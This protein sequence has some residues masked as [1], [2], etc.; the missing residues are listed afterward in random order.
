MTNDESSPNNEARKYAV[1]CQ[2]A[3]RHLSFVIP[4][5]F[6]LRHL[7]EIPRLTLGMTNKEYRGRIAPSPTG[8][9][10][11]G[12]AMTFWRAQ[13]RARQVGGKLVLRIED[14]DR[15]RCRREFADAIIEDLHWFGLDW[16]EGPDIG[17]PFAPYFQSQRRSRYLEAWEKLRVG[18]FVYPCKC[19]RKDVMEA[20]LAPHDESEEPIYPGT[21]RPRSSGIESAARR[22]E[23]LRR[24][25]PA[26]GWK[27]LQATRLPLQGRG[28]TVAAA[29]SA[30]GQGDLPPATAAAT[31]AAQTHWRFRVPDGPRIEFVDERVGKQSAVAGR[32]FGDFIVWRRDDVPAYQLAVVVD[33]AAMRI[34]EVVRGEDLLRSTFRQL[35][36]YRALDLTPPQFFHTQ[37]VV[38]ESGKRLAKRHGA[39]NLRALRERGAVPEEL[40]AMYIPE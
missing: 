31:S 22:A 27:N 19:S 25:V 16:D 15:D 33:D 8:L 11:L 37:L 13:E 21:C 14:L 20:S 32:D 2:T 29:V 17:G 36:L 1:I 35:L 38:D 26:A 30:A 9:L 7:K 18:G 28:K 10:H 5:S 34:S 12:H 40:R 24:R 6:V 4:S 23:A 3:F 39:L